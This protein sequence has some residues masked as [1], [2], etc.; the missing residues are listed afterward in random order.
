MSSTIRTQSLM[1]EWIGWRPHPGKRQIKQTE[2][3]TPCAAS[4]KTKKR[5]AS[6]T[7]R[8]K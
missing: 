4:V 8:E 3:Q 1:Y 2:H 6:I 5:R 7:E